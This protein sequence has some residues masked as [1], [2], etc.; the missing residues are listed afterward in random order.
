M[1]PDCEP[2]GASGS[3]SPSSAHAASLPPGVSSWCWA[4]RSTAVHARLRLSSCSP[5][6][7]SPGR[8]GQ[9][10]CSL[11]PRKLF[12]VWRRP[13]TDTTQAPC[14]QP[15]PA[16]LWPS[17]LPRLLSDPPP[18]LLRVSTAAA[19]CLAR[20][21]PARPFAITFRFLLGE[22]WRSAWVRTAPTAFGPVRC[23]RFLVLDAGPLALAAANSGGPQPGDGLLYEYC[24][25]AL[26]WYRSSYSIFK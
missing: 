23:P 24:R 25:S 17:S 13:T 4:A 21:E 15:K 3:S 5:L 14:C 12:Q 1:L 11:P 2:Q 19:P 8:L 9:H 16:E 26:A 7:Q 18:W 10:A 22:G 6:L 20:P